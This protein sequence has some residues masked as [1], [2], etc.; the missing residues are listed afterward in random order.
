MVVMSGRLT[1]SVT[2]DPARGYIGTSPD[3]REPI[4]ALSLGGMRRKAEI[5]LLPDDIIVALSLDR[6]A[7]LERDRRRRFPVAGVG[8]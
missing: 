2:H 1:I 3:L 8:R 6:R 4:I 5:A 7:R